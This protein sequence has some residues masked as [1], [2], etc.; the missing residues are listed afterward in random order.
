MIC[1]IF[2]VYII[3][4]FHYTLQCVYHHKFSFRPSPNHWP[5]LPISSSPTSLPLFLWWTLIC[6]LYL[7]VYSF[8]FYIPLMNEIIWYSLYAVGVISLG[9]I[10]SSS[11]SCQDFILFKAYL[12]SVLY[13]CVMTSL[14]IHPSLGTWVVSIAFLL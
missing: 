13:M 14:S 11:M 2:H 5:Q 4:Q 7:F 8:I 9:I 10:L 12:Y 1:N 6:S 3:F